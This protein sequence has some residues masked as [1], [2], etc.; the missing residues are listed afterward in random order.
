MVSR[1]N[2]SADLV[3]SAARV[4]GLV[5]QSILSDK[6][7]RLVLRP[8]I[9][10]DF[11]A[12]SM[13]SRSYRQQVLAAISG[14]EGLANNLPLSALRRMEFSVPPIDI[15]RNIVKREHVESRAIER[16]SNRVST[17]ILLLE[18]FRT[19]LVADVVTGQVDVRAVA[20]TLPDPIMPD[21]SL[22]EDGTSLEDLLGHEDD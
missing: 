9:D 22:D 14:A 2:G 13:N 8:D 1:A 19:R 18:E 12:I 5:H 17:E 7:F 6:T 3:G 20:E 10:T 4:V 11:L 16:T 21:V 15:Q